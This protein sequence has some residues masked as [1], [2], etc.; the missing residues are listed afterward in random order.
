MHFVSSVKLCAYVVQ[1]LDAGIRALRTSLEAGDV[2]V[3]RW[4]LEPTDGTDSRGTACLRPQARGV[5]DE[6]PGLLRLEQHA[7]HVRRPAR[8]CGRRRRR[9]SRNFRVGNSVATSS[10]GP[11]ISV[12]DADR[13]ICAVDAR[14]YGD[15]QDRSPA[16]TSERRARVR[17]CRSA[18]CTPVRARLS[19][20]A[21]LR[22]GLPSP[23]TRQ[24]LNAGVDRGTGQ[25]DG[26]RR[27]EQHRRAGR[28][29]STSARPGYCFL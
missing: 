9:R 6:V 23:V 11:A 29:Q 18:A 19:S 10:I 20:G 7:L 16:R 3:D 25:S 1:C 13:E 28:S 26:N 21:L 5:A 2:A 17:R 22:L 15:S 8:E 4:D 24:A 27:G 14:M 12:S